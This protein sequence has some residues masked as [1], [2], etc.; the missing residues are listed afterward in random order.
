MWLATWNVLS[1]NRVG[2]LRNLKGQLKQ[3]EVSWSVAR[4]TDLR[5]LYQIQWNYDPEVNKCMRFH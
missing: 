5:S 3:Y 1:L 2:V 4:D